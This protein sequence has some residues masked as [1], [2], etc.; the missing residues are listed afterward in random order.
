[1]N[2][3]ENTDMKSYI[4]TI[5]SIRKD[6]YDPETGEVGENEV[7]CA[8]PNEREFY[9]DSTQEFEEKL[10]T[11]LDIP[12]ECV[13]PDICEDCNGLVCISYAADGDGN[14]LPC[15]DKDVEFVHDVYVRVAQ[16]LDEEDLGGIF[17]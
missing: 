3:I 12:V 10:A 13:S 8:L 7:E 5:V 11:I 14:R 9:F 16:T 17:A 6:G 4:A 2:D 15:D 1:M